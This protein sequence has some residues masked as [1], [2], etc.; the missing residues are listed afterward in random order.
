MTVH[1]GNRA[2]KMTDNQ[3]ERKVKIPIREESSRKK[4]QLKVTK[5]QQDEDGEKTI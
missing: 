1:T 3:P 2:M 4:L 5:Y